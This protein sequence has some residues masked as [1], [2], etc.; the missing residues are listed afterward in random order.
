MRIHGEDNLFYLSSQDFK[1]KIMKQ[2][3][4]IQ[5]ILKDLYDI[6]D[7]LRSFKLISVYPLLYYVGLII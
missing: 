5:S 7:L 1:K 4:N 2:S 3:C 6:K